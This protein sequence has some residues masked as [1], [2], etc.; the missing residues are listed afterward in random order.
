MFQYPLKVE[1]SKVTLATPFAS[2]EI[3]LLSQGPYPLTPCAGE[4]IQTKRLLKFSPDGGAGYICTTAL[5]GCPSTT[6]F[7][8]VDMEQE[9]LTISTSA[10]TCGINNPKPFE[11]KIATRIRIRLELRLNLPM[12]YLW[13]LLAI[14]VFLYGFVDQFKSNF[15]DEHFSSF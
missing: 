2:L 3:L 5:M 7:G 10:L 11:H 13:N 14:K 9:V 8:C 6:L 12:I 1:I 4:V 15:L